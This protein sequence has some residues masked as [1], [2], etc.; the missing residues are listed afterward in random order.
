MKKIV[1][2]ICAIF[3]FSLSGVLGEESDNNICNYLKDDLGLKEGLN[4]P[5][6]IPYSNEIFNIY[7]KENTPIGHIE[8]KD[9]T[10]VSIGCDVKDKSTFNI[11]I[12][13][14][15]TIS[16][17]ASSTDQLSELNKKIKSKDLEIKG[18]SFGKKI[19]GAFTR[20]GLKIAGWFK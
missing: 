9:K 3:L 13:D 1:L 12:K 11:Y 19:K 6:Q 7:T 8:I 15:Q 5:S 18:A 4:L 16:D 10:I 14:K 17:I 2:L 20:L